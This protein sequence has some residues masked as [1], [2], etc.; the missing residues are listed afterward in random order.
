MQTPPF[1]VLGR[2]V[3]LTLQFSFRKTAPPRVL[4]FNCFQKQLPFRLYAFAVH[5]ASSVELVSMPF[6]I[7]LLDMTVMYGIVIGKSGSRHSVLNINMG[8]GRE[9]RRYSTTS[10]PPSHGEGAGDRTLIETLMR[11]RN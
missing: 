1:A 8:K 10:P 3:A 11:V 5:G 7:A 2:H 6:C 4:P 9:G